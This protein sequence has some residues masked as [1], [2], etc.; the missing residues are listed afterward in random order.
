MSQIRVSK[1]HA[2]PPT[3]ILLKKNG[4]LSELR[5]TY[6][7]KY[8]CCN[9]ENCYYRS[10]ELILA[11]RIHHLKYMP[12]NLRDKIQRSGNLNSLTSTRDAPI[13]TVC[14]NKRLENIETS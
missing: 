4:P 6:A 2:A 11:R 13:H 9:I 7:F 12:L 5:N 3:N 10:T 1:A 8:Y 14:Q